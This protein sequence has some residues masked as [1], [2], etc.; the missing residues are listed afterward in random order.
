MGEATEDQLLARSVMRYALA[1]LERLAE[2]TAAELRGCPPSGV[3]GYE[4][5]P[6]SMWDEYCYDQQ[7]GPAAPLA[8]A[9]T[10][11]IS[12]H[13]ERVIAELDRTEAVLLTFYLCW[14]EQTDPCEVVGDPPEG[15]NEEALVSAIMKELDRL[16]LDH[17]L[18]G[19]E[20]G[21]DDD[22]HDR[23]DGSDDV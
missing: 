19:E 6:T 17:E 5:N 22:D 12:P 3:L 23:D 1:R 13:V 10:H 14:D 21:D 7:N 20:W 8:S 15:V 2:D 11:T 16:A 9:W 18:P 4:G